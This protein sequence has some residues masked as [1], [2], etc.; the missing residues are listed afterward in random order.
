MSPQEGATP[1][2]LLTSRG[3]QLEFSTA[4]S[5]S[6]GEAVSELHTRAQEQLLNIAAV[7]FLPK[8]QMRSPL[9]AA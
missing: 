4:E 2:A 3:G 8:A 1:E 6:S 5:V 7:L 9:G